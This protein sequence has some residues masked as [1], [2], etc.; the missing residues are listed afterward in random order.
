[1]T[2][3]DLSDPPADLRLSLRMPEKVLLLGPSGI[4]SPTVTKFRTLGQPLKPWA[5]GLIVATTISYQIA[6]SVKETSHD[7]FHFTSEGFFGQHTY[8]GG[9]DKA[10]HL[11]DYTIAQRA[12]MN[13]YRRVGYTSTQS[14][15]LGFGTVFAAGLTNEIGD[16]TTLFGFSYE[17]LVM[18]TL[19]AGTATVLQLTGWNDTFGFR[20]GPI[21]QQESPSCC[22]DFSNVGR[23]YSGEIYTA[24]FKIAGLARRLRFDPGPAR[25]LLF[26]VTYG[27]NG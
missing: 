2:L 10:A 12:L 19:G 23:D 13:T 3:I 6:N 11:V 5:T 7:G 14:A 4:P 27:T 8:A 20:F 17:D 22:L 18:D 1:M 15:W 24:D 25:F 9:V 21:S 16:G 26:S